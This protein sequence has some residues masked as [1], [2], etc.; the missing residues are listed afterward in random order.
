MTL[1]SIDQRLTDLPFDQWVRH[2]F[3]HE[4]R[5]PEW[6]FDLDA[7]YWDGPPALTVAYMTRLFAD[8]L[9]AAGG[10]T[11]AQ[12]N[13]GL[14]Y[15]ASNSASNCMLALGDASVPLTERVRCLRAIF[16]LYR[17]LF[18]PRCSPHL[19]HLSE[20]GTSP[21]NSVCYMWWDLVPLVA[22]PAD[23]AW[24]PMDAAILEVMAQTLA[25]PSPACQE[26]ALHGLGHWAWAYPRQVKEII[27][28]FLTRQPQLRPELRQYAKAAQSGC[29]L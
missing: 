24:S 20:E 3:D 19:G 15:V 13:Q 12:L 22:S 5:Q 6:Y 16:P 17:D 9:A 10:Y 1:D 8:P 23:P 18:A 26:G 2:V 7:A 11:D 14:W 25:L 27:E 4:V 28:R 29:V 21:L